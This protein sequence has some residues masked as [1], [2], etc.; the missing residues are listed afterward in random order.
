MA[1]T[2]AIKVNIKIEN[3]S[4][5]AIP[6]ATVA[7]NTCHNMINCGLTSTTYHMAITSAIKNNIS[8]NNIVV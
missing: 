2:S 6:S 4:Q 7:N 5:L 1:K 3:K 8:I